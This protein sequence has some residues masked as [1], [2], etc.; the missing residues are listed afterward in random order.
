[1]GPVAGS[2]ADPGHDRGAGV[3]SIVIAAYNEAAV[4][5]RC[6][7]ALLSGAA[8]G[9]FDVTVVANGCTDDTAEVAARAGVR[10]LDLSSPGKTGGPQRRGRGRGRIP[11]DLSRRRRRADRRGGTRHRRRAR[12]RSH[13]HRWPRY[14]AGRW[15]WPA[16]RCW[17]ARTSPFTVDCRCFS[18]RC[19]AVASS[20]CRRLAGPGSTCSR[21]SSPTT[22]SSMDCSL[23][24]RRCRS[25]PSRRGWRRRGEPATCSTGCPGYGGATL[26]CAPARRP[27]RGCATR[28]GCRGCATWCCPGR[29]SPR[30]PSATSR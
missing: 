20:R 28:T 22:C 7:D 6:L 18:A 8:P 19:S 11:Q 23:K 15:M 17:Y 27:G 2:A 5:G 30:P 26:S 1:M 12:G 24:P 25:S 4:I 29:G 16:G 10:V 9:E 3:T 14:R 13:N 21:N